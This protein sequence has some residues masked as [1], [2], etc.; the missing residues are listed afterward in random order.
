MDS[1]D[2]GAFDLEGLSVGDVSL[3]IVRFVLVDVLLKVRV[4]AYQVWDT[5]CVVSVLMG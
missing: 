5:A 2:R 4:Q 3:A 1:A